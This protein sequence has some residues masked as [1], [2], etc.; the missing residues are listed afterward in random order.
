MALASVFSL[1]LLFVPHLLL[2]AWHLLLLSLFLLFVPQNPFS[3][4]RSG[5]HWVIKKRIDQAEK[6]LELTVLG[7]IILGITYDSSKRIL[8]AFRSVLAETKVSSHRA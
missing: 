7:N 3:S 8:Q 1:F 5:L 4:E 2:L 6:F